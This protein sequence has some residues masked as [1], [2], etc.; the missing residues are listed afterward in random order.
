MAVS[1]SAMRQSSVLPAKAI[2]VI[3]VRM[4]ILVRDMANHSRRYCVTV[5]F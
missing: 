2:M 5:F 3:N 1:L 4:N